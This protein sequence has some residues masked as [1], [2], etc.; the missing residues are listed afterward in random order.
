MIYLE[1][2][3]KSYGVTPVL[4]PLSCAIPTQEFVFLM[5]PS[6]AGKSTLLR[7]LSFVEAPDSGEITL[8]LRGS[9]F[10]SRTRNNPPWP[11]VTAVFQRQFLWPHLTIRENIMLPLHAAAAPN[12]DRKVHKLE[13]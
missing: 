12:A 11:R 13:P 4:G 9:H 3:T 8:D 5:G 7:L 6:G 10:S 1:G 2:V